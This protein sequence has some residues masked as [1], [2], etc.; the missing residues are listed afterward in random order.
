M[1]N[2]TSNI[3]DDVVTSDKE[4]I[5]SAIIKE[6]KSK[7]KGFFILLFISFIGGG[8]VGALMTAMDDSNI[9]MSVADAVIGFIEGISVYVSAVLAVVSLPVFVVLYTK[10]RKGYEAWDGEDE[11]Q[12]K[13]IDGKLSMMLFISSI[14]MII[15]YVFMI[16]GF[17]R[18]M[19]IDKSQAT[20]FWVSFAFLIGGFIAVTVVITV[21]QQKAVNLGKAMNPEKRGSVFDTKFQKKWIKSCDEAEKKMIHEAAFAAYKATNTAIMIIWFL[22]L[23]GTIMFDIGILP[24]FIIGV[25]WMVQ[26]VAYFVK[27]MQLEKR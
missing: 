5:E 17:G 8:V 18:L 27:G 22:C 14:V 2:D 25:I 15:S 1:N 12:Y 4:Q 23:A 9:I 10:A 24:V 7:L 21:A 20:L 16:T 3:I 6:D 11:D 26:T 13:A 19:S